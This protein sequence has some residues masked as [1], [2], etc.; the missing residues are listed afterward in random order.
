[1][2]HEAMLVA[3]TTA[4]TVGRTNHNTPSSRL[5]HDIS[6]RKPIVF[7]HGDKVGIILAREPLRFLVPHGTHPGILL[8]EEKILTSSFVGR[9]GHDT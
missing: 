4:M 6:M 1:M 9:F 2:M 5:D 3:M 7:L 8:R